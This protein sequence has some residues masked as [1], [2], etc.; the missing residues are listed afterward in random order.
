MDAIPAELS[1][2]IE[3]SDVQ[4]GAYIALCVA[5]GLDVAAGRPP[6][7]AAAISYL[8]NG[9]DHGRI[10]QLS[11]EAVDARV[12]DLVMSLVRLRQGR[13]EALGSLE[14]PLVLGRLAIVLGS[15]GDPLWLSHLVYC[16]RDCTLPDGHS[17]Y[18]M[19]LADL[20]T[21]Q[22]LDLDAGADAALMVRSLR[23]SR[24]DSMDHPIF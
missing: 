7:S 10:E 11:S 12:H 17:D 20:I 24:D 22:K 13:D 1:A 18:A 19:V 9:C 16:Q 4:F 5:T 14:Y 3:D 2:A 8:M 6:S 23:R 21:S 15:L